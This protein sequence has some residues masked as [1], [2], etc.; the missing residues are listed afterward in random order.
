MVT[1]RESTGFRTAIESTARDPETRSFGHVIKLMSSYD[2]DGPCQRLTV[3][4]IRDRLRERVRSA[5]E[6]LP[7][8]QKRRVASSTRSCAAAVRDKGGACVGASSIP[9][10]N[11]LRRS[12]YGRRG[13]ALTRGTRYGFTRAG[14]VGVVMRVVLDPLYASVVARVLALSR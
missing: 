2:P 1:L 13:A 9:S 8:E 11:G 5:R 6:V 7:S 12:C 10:F 14:V 3:E 4:S